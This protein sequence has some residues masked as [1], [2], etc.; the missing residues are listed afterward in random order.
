[1]PVSI[2]GWIR[3]TLIVVWLLLA[4]VSA[5]QGITNGD[6]GRTVFGIATSAILLIYL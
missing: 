1:M 2:W 4:V 5:V 3:A 6:E